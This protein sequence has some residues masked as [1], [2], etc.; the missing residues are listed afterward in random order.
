MN[1]LQDKVILVTG[2]TRGIGKA[3]VLE[4]AHQGANV[5]FTYAGSTELAAQLENEIQNIGVKGKSYQADAGDFTKA[6]EVV[7]AVVAEAG[8]LD[9]LINNA[10]ITRDN[11]LLR[12][13]EQQWDEVINANLK[14]AFNYTK[15]VAKQMLGQRNG[16]IL[17]MSSVVGVG[18][19]A[20]QANYAAS[21]AGMIGLTKSVA[22]EFASRNIRCNAIAPGFIAT[23]MTDKIPPA[24]LEKWIKNIPLGRAGTADEIAKL[25]VFLSS[26]WAGYITGQVIQ[27]DGGME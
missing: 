4:M 24:E 26:D 13:N 19:N 15:A 7:N 2:G 16:V 17:N 21:K 9:V 23:E 10:G 22:K 18:G 8:R 14:S 6:Q 27:V 12:M 11:L 20:G 3:I 25:C 1:L 5:Y